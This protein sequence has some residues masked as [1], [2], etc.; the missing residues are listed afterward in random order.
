MILPFEKGPFTL[1]KIPDK[2]SSRF[3]NI[4]TLGQGTYGKVHLVYDSKR[5]EEYALKFNFIDENYEETVGSIREYDILSK[6]DDHPFCISIPLIFT[7]PILFPVSPPKD[8]KCDPF[9]YAFKPGSQNA[10]DFIRKGTIREKKLLLLHL[11][12]AIEYLHSRDIIH[13]DVKPQNIIVC[14][15]EREEFEKGQLADLGLAT[16]YSSHLLSNHVLVTVPYRAPDVAFQRQYDKKIDI[17]AVGMTILEIFEKKGKIFIDVSNNRELLSEIATKCD[18]DE[19]FWVLR[20]DKYGSRIPRSRG[21][22]LLYH[23]K[24]HFGFSRPDEIA[25]DSP[26]IKGRPNHG[27]LKDFYQILQMMLRVNP[28]ERASATDLLNHSFFEGHR[29]FIQKIRSQYEINDEGVY[30]TLPP[31]SWVVGDL[32]NEDVKDREETFRSIYRYIEKDLIPSEIAFFMADLTERFL[33][34]TN[35][36]LPIWINTIYLMG[37]KQHR[38]Y[39]EENKISSLLLDTPVLDREKVMEKVTKLERDLLV[40]IIPKG[41]LVKQGYYDWPFGKEEALTFLKLLISLPKGDYPL[42]GLLKKMIPSP[43]GQKEKEKH[44]RF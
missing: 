21:H 3:R 12:L 43:G 38:L 26:S 15:N 13:G 34:Q 10:F 8:M 30:I 23:I 2:M 25:F 33:S 19:E 7:K 24:K 31:P 44:V 6:L 37:L 27:S 22:G 4:K 20:Q 11:L 16:V 39:D 35:A 40:D 5:Q 14:L 29:E 28:K 9:T 41:D 17:W 18:V 1:Q 36:E 32:R 42:S